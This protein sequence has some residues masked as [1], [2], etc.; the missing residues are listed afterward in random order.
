[1]VQTVTHRDAVGALR[2]LHQHRTLV[3]TVAVTVVRGG[4]IVISFLFNLVLARSTGTDGSGVYFLAFTIVALTAIVARF[5]CDNALVRLVAATDDA[6]A[7]LASAYVRVALAVTTGIG[8]TATALMAA[9]AGVVADVVFGDPSLAPPLRA[10][11]LAITPMALTSVLGRTMIGRG[12][13]VR[14]VL[15]E[16]AALPALHLILYLT[17]LRPWGATGAAMSLSLSNAILLA[18]GFLV[19]GPSV[20][21]RPNAGPGRNRRAWSELRRASMPL[22]AVTLLGSFAGFSGTVLLGVLSTTA[23]AGTFAVASRTAR[24]G[25]LL[26]T[27]LNTSIAPQFARLYGRGD[28]EELRSALRRSF[29]LLVPVSLVVTIPLLVLAR[30]LMSLFG[31]DFEAGT[32]VLRILALATGVNIAT[33]PLNIYLQMTARERRLR[34]ITTVSTVAQIGV[35]AALIPAFG[36]EGAAVGVLVGVILLNAWCGIVIRTEDPH[37]VDIR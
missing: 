22:L 19:A 32:G 35:G 15:V 2:P 7:A 10:M 20:R 26:L 28:F 25:Q 36:G 9:S 11:S 17:L 23:A 1:V 18:V 33:G 6:G 16:G 3:N 34:T 8:L 24:V 21:S 29:R 13:V 4:S 37:S 30:P 27:S 14:G 12:Q 5:G 31:D